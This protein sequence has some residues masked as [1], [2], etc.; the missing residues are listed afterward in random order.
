MY[1]YIVICR[2]DIHYFS[3]SPNNQLEVEVTLAQRIGPLSK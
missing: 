1:I 2:P 3:L